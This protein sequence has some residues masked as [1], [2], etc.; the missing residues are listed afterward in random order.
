MVWGV[1]VNQ[2]VL[3]KVEG[4]DRRGS[5]ANGCTVASSVLGAR[6]S[7]PTEPSQEGYPIGITVNIYL[8]NRPRIVW[9][10]CHAT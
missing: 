5:D 7:N 8:W 3:H 4:F 9:Y 1:R 6:R 10:R 2:N